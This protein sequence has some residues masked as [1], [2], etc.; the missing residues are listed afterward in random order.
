MEDRTA[1][2]QLLA[3]LTSSL[4]TAGA[5]SAQELLPLV[6][7]ELHKLAHAYRRQRSVGETLRTTALV[8]DVYLKLIGSREDG[9]EGRSHFLAVA[10]KAVR[11]VLANHARDR[12]ALKRGGNWARVTLSALG[13]EDAAQ[14]VDL[15]HLD[16]ALD[17]LSQ[18]DE[19]QGELVEMR[20]LAGMSVEETAEALGVST[21]TVEREWRAARAWLSAELQKMR[22]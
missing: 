14:D 16:Q 7:E 17:K 4:T 1:P 5:S 2:P 20:H 18:L 15:V 11:Q 12:Q 8:H 19:R 6:Y 22:A 13:S 10:A 9:W 21:R 3:H